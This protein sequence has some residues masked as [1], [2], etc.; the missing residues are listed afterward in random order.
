MLM[1]R[2]LGI[3]GA[4]VHGLGDTI[5]CVDAGQFGNFFVW[6]VL[7]NGAASMGWGRRERE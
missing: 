5:C 7:F 2:D 1:P 4:T 6:W 3:L